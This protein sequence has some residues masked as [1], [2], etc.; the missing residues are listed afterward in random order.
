LVERR[1]IGAVTTVTQC[2]CYSNI[3]DVISGE[4]E[5]ESE[6]GDEP[7]EGAVSGSTE[8]DMIPP[9]VGGECSPVLTASVSST[10]PPPSLVRQPNEDIATGGN[11]K[12]KKAT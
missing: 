2:H 12:G 7:P 9:A 1:E 5:W 6:C 4:E 8:D 10:S 3:R 11:H